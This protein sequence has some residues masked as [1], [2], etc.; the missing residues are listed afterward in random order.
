MSKNYSM[1]R[2]KFIAGEYYHICNKS[3]ANYGIFKDLNNC[4]RFLE[5]LDYYN[6]FPRTE[7]FSLCLK[8][9]AYKYNNLLI[10]K[11]NS[12]VKYIAY[13]IMPD[14]YHLLL[15]LLVQNSFSKFIND[16]ENS[17]SRYFNC[18]FERKGPL[19]QSRFRAVRVR[20]NEQLLHVSRYIHLNPTTASLVEKPEEWAY[21]SYGDYLKEGKIYK[22]FISDISIKTQA[23][24]KR[25]TEDQIDYQKRLKLIKR[26]L[27]D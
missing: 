27:L 10:P 9:K 23:S 17:F 11:G 19:W 20:S 13:C 25:F 5:T 22:E 8:R 4:Q 2:E 18:K 26:I 24:Y 21:S 6:N 14:H 3:I 12:T 15:R 1:R 7:S 16:I